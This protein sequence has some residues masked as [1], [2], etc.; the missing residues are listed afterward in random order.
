MPSSRRQLPRRQ[1]LL[2]RAQGEVRRW[3]DVTYHM[4]YNTPPRT[5]NVC[6]ATVLHCQLTPNIRR[7]AVS[8]Q[9]RSDAPNAMSEKNAPNQSIVRKICT[10][11]SR[12]RHGDLTGAVGYEPN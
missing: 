12:A 5:S 2:C 3:A 8:R 10:S 9:G 7:V 6:C 1:P 4:M 11:V